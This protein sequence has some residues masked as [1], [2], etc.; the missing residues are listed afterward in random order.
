M[1]KKVY[2]GL[3][4]VVFLALVITCAM[5]AK[6]GIEGGIGNF[7]FGYLG[8]FGC[9]YLALRGIDWGVAAQACE[10]RSKRR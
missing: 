9:L 8:A 5:L 4:M 1:M 3:V 10:E 2:F 6:D 7:I